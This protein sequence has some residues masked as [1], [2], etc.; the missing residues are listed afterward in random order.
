MHVSAVTIELRYTLRAPHRLLLGESIPPLS[1]FFISNDV[2][3][4]V[5]QLFLHFGK[6]H[7]ASVEML[8]SCSLLFLLL[9]LGLQ[10]L[11][12]GGE[13]IV[14]VLL[15]VAPHGTHAGAE[16]LRGK[17]APILVLVL[18]LA[19]LFTRFVL[20]LLTRGLGAVAVSTVSLTC[21]LE[22]THPYDKKR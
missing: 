3:G 17:V 10:V 14:L 21:W 9:L 4:L 2:G 12:H 5:F 13:R 7:I 1:L 8:F 15:E 11:L 6:V 18:A 22:R 16:V 20:A 19:A